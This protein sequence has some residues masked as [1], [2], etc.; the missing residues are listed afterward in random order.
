MLALAASLSVVPGVAAIGPGGWD[1]VGVGVTS[2]TPSLDGPVY[3]L[4]ADSPGVL[5]VGG[6]FTAAGGNA[7]A[8]RIATWNGT[9]WGALNGPRISNGAVFAIAFHDG[10]VY[11]GGTFLNAGGNSTADFLAVWDGSGWGPVCNATGAAFGGSVKALQVI[12]NTLWIGGSF[13][14]AAGIAS[15]DFLVGCDLTTGAPMSTVDADGGINGA[16]LALAADSNGTLYAG[17][18]FI[19]MS[20]I[21]AADHVAAYDGTWHAMGAGVS[22]GAGAVDS[23]VRALATHGTDVYVGTDSV[24]V[25]GIA[26]ADHVA[27]WNGASWSAIGTDSTGTNGWFTTGTFINALATSGS[28]V[29]AA[30]SFQ[31]ANGVATADHIAYFDG[32]TWRPIGSNGAGNGPFVAN[33]VALELFRSKLYAA[34]SFTSAGGDVRARA[35]A[36]YALMQ[37]DARIATAS[38]GPFTGNAIYSPTA[39]GE[40]RTRTVARRHS[41]TF[42]VSIQNDGLVAASFKILG[43]GGAHGYSVQY[44]RGAVNVTTAVKAGTYST[45]AIA[46]RAA[47]TLKVV[48]TLGSSTAASASYLVKALSVSGTWSDAVKA[49]VKAS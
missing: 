16:V 14:N 9:A 45:G 4:N 22:A 44:Y 8:S 47:I 17:G 35:L 29:F 12:G 32:T 46:A 43:T 39:V 48:V 40:S 41:G 24:N 25:A 49:I 2:A 31:N 3:A 11:A 13:A 1:H 30:G 20:H 37:P 23:Y 5:L 21:A 38:A 18:Q 27:M 19:N 36:S 10:K 26:A 15:A 34:G 7:N 28:L 33:M 42:Y 6:G